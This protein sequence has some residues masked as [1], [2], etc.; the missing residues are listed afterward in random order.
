MLILHVLEYNL[1]IVK[2][3]FIMREWNTVKAHLM[4]IVGSYIIC[5]LTYYVLIANEL[6]NTYDGMWKGTR[7]VEYDWVVKIGRWFWPVIGFARGHL[8]PEPFTSMLSIALFVLGAWLVVSMFDGW[9]SVLKCFTV[10]LIVV[11]TSV[12]VA[13]SYRY[14]SPT[15]AFAFLFSTA[16]AWVIAKGIRFGW[17]IYVLLILLTLASYQGT[18]GCAGVLL[19]LHIIEMLSCGEKWK[20]IARFLMKAGLGFGLACLLYKVIWD[21]G[22]NLLGF[23]AASYRGADMVSVGGILLALPARMKDAYRAYVDFVLGRESIRYNVWQN[24][25]P[26]VTIIYGGCVLFAVILMRNAVRNSL[27]SRDRILRVAAVLL[28]FVL[29]PAAANVAMLLSPEGGGM[30][31]QM[32]MPMTMMI[33]SFFSFADK[34]LPYTKNKYGISCW[35]CC[36]ILLSVMILYGSFLQVSIDQHI[37]LKSRTDTLAIMNRVVADIERRGMTEPEQGFVFFGKPVDNP[38]FRKDEVW[39]YA[40]AYAQ[41]GNFW[42]GGNCCTQSYYGVLRD[43]GYDLPFNWEDGYWHE[44]EQRKEIQEMPAYPYEGY[45]QKIDRVYAVKLAD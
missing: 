41:Y 14:M 33:P 10:L 42:M 7:Y 2:A 32:T 23:E 18:V 22:M 38:Q 3:G 20:E 31:I 13:L 29:L 26:F 24:W 4:Q 35:K 34:C 21:T 11:N 36:S 16:A 44:L 1:R 9:N 12:C 15:F 17:V 30:M 19:V 39:E 5:C 6:T 8:S 28:S 37:M 25:P 45:I 27:D 40:N 43:G